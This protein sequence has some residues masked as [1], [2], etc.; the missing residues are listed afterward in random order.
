MI[1]R[2]FFVWCA[3]DQAPH[4]SALTSTGTSIG[5]SGSV[6]GVLCTC[7]PLPLADDAEF[8][9]LFL[10]FESNSI[11]ISLNTRD[12]DAADCVAG[13]AVDVLSAPFL[14]SLLRNSSASASFI[15]SP[16]CSLWSD[17]EAFFDSHSAT[18]AVSLCA[19]PVLDRVAPRTT[20]SGSEFINVLLCDSFPLDARS[21]KWRWWSTRI[22]G[23][24]TVHPPSVNLQRTP[25]NVV[26][27]LF[28]PSALRFPSSD[29][30]SS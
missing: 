13:A 22:S 27:C 12:V 18:I 6:S 4:L 17:P 3:L 30:T 28:V 16:F 24:F 15:T 7:C 29:F 9:I 8:I 25:N 10:G 19:F 5:V 11:C 14:Y 26:E 2:H 20:H 21:C 23:L 1:Y